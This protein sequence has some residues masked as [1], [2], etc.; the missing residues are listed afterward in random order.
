MS[1]GCI[2]RFGVWALCSNCFRG[3]AVARAAYLIWRGIQLMRK[4]HGAIIVAPQNKNAQVHNHAGA[5]FRAGSITNLPYPHSCCFM[6]RFF[7]RRCAW[8]QL[9]HPADDDRH[10][11][12]HQSVMVWCRRHIVLSSTRVARM[13]GR[14]KSWIERLCGAKLVFFGLRQALSFWPLADLGLNE[15]CFFRIRFTSSPRLLVFIFMLADMW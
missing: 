2:I 14:C 11:A 13:Y 6:H 15:P 7:R 4:S 3:C 10:G 5:V 9:G 12:H 1:G 8:H